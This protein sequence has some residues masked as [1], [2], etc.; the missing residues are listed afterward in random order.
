MGNKGKSFGIDLSSFGNDFQ[1][2]AE[3]LQANESVIHSSGAKRLIY[4]YKKK[5]KNKKQEF[6][7]KS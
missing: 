6:V 1:S 4:F 2:Q 7:K 3:Q 5:K